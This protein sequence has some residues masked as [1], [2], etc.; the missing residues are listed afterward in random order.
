R[1][2]SAVIPL[3]TPV[4]AA[5][6]ETARSLPASTSATS[7]SSHEGGGALT[8]WRCGCDGLVRDGFSRA[9]D[10][11]RGDD[12]GGWSGDVWACRVRHTAAIGNLGMRTQ[13]TR[14]CSAIIHLQRPAFTTLLERDRGRAVGACDAYSHRAP[15]RV[16]AVL[17]G[18]DE[19]GADIACESRESYGDHARRRRRAVHHHER[20]SAGAEEEIG[21]PCG[22]GAGGGT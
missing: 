4:R 8:A 3:R 19:G 20:E 13:A 16:A 2:S 18:D 6:P 11:V 12:G 9:F 15:R 14:H 10:G 17:A 22:A 1:A 21:A 5:A 7:A